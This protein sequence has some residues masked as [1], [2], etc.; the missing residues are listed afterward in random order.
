MLRFRKNLIGD[1]NK[2]TECNSGETK[3]SISNSKI[4]TS[5]QQKQNQQNQCIK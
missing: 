2:L 5:N 4:E 1:N 3:L